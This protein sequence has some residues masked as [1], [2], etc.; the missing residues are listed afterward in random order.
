MTDKNEGNSSQMEVA[1]PSF[2]SLILAQRE[3]RG[4]NDQSAWPGAEGVVAWEPLAITQV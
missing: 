2:R 1:A 3:E 4:T